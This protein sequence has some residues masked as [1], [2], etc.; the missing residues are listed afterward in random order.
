MSTPSY[1]EPYVISHPGTQY[2]DEVLVDGEVYANNP[3][4]YAYTLAAIGMSKDNIRMVSI[5]TGTPPN[6]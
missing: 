4:F 6:Q 1:F 5:G 2:E 3:S